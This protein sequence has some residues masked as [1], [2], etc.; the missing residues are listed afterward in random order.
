MASKTSRDLSKLLIR[1]E[2]N[3]DSMEQAMG[4]FEKLRKRPVFSYGVFAI[5]LAVIQLLS[6]IGI[7]SSSFVT[8]IGITAIYSIVGL[9]FCLLLGYSALASLGTAGFIGIGAYAA[10]FCIVEW[11]LTMGIAGF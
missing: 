9:G 11:G 5:V 10:Y 4:F 8:A 1:D 6:Q 3:N 7:V 2:R